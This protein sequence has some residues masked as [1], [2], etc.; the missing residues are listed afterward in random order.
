MIEK[1]APAVAWI[2]YG[3]DRL[4]RSLDAGKERPK[5]EEIRVQKVLEEQ[6]KTI[7]PI[8]NAKGKLIEYYKGRHLDIFG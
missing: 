3:Y 4:R 1:I 2:G 6:R 5:A 7:Q 8:Y